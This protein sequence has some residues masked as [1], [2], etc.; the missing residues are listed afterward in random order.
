[1]RR[2]KVAD[3]D[4]PDLKRPRPGGIVCGCRL[5]MAAAVAF[6]MFAVIAV[7]VCGLA[8][9]RAAVVRSKRVGRTQT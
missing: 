5:A 3:V 4:V 9:I 6:A 1:M 7:I 8:M 2:T